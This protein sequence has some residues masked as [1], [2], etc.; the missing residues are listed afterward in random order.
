MKGIIYK[1]LYAFIKEC[2]YDPK[3]GLNIQYNNDVYGG[4]EAMNKNIE[5]LNFISSS[6]DNEK[7]VID[8]IIDKGVEEVSS[9]QY[10]ITVDNVKKF[11][12]KATIIPLARGAY[13]RVL[14]SLDEEQFVR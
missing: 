14:M 11:L 10:L 4:N 9:N 3:Y 7:K 2:L 13:E 1:E 8:Q 6:L 12:S 5:V